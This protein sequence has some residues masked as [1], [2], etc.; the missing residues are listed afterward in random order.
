MPEEFFFN[1]ELEDNLGF[2]RSHGAEKLNE[3]ETEKQIEEFK[4]KLEAFNSLKAERKMKPNISMDWIN[5][6]RQQLTGDDN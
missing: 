1:A 3:E 6:L 5:K 4:Q 2:N